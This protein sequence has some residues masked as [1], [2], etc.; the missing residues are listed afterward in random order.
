MFATKN[1]GQLRARLSAIQREQRLGKLSSERYVAQ[2]VEVLAALKKLGEPLSDDE[3][4]FLAQH[5]TESM[6]AFEGSTAASTL[7]Q[8]AQAS[9]LSAAASSVKKAQK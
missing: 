8:S 1:G 3:V 6:A 7:N 2:A 5:M 9:L 4:A